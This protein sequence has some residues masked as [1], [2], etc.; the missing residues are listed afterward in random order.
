MAGGRTGANRCW[1]ISKLSSPTTRASNGTD[2]GFQLTA[3]QCQSLREEAVQYYQ[4]Y[5]SLFVLED[6]EGVVRDTAAESSRAGYV[7]AVRRR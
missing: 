4:R 2:L 1:S 7:R 5:L 6:F 3:N